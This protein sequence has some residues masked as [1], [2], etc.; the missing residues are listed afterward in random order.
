MK[1]LYNSIPPLSQQ[2]IDAFYEK[3][4]RLNE[5]QCWEWNGYKNKDG[6][7][8]YSI[9]I[10]V[11]RY[12]KK[13]YPFRASRI[14]FYINTGEDPREMRVCHT[15]DNPGCCNP[16]HLFLGTDADNKKDSIIKG[17]AS[18]YF[19]GDGVRGGKGIRRAASPANTKL[20]QVDIEKIFELRNGNLSQ[21][22][23]ADIFQVHQSEISKILNGKR[24]IR[25]TKNLPL[26]QQ[27]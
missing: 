3:I 27:V 15:C 4:N 13:T 6:Y 1:L 19:G 23:I 26:C 12:S 18:F 8:V 2:T 24:H 17:R 22:V 7:G 5:R 16:S 10:P 21:F 9:P 25:L 14:A 20:S 11:D